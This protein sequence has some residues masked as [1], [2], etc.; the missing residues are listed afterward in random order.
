MTPRR[1]YHLTER[2]AAECRLTPDDVTVLLSAHR[3][4]VRVTPTTSRGTY[5]VVPA[6]HVGVIVGPSCRLVIQPKVPL[7]NLFHLL[8]PTGPLPVI[9]DQVTPESG[10]EALDFLAARLARLLGERAAAGLHRAYAERRQAGPYLQGRLDMA[11]QVRTPAVRK[12]RVHS[13]YDEF[14]ADVPCNQVPRATAE[15]VLASPLLGDPARAALRTA[16]AGYADVRAIP[17]DPAAFAAAAPDRRTEAYRPLLDLCRLLAQELTPGPDAGPAP[18]PAFLLDL[19]RVFEQYVT[20]G[21]VEACAGRPGYTA[22]VQP[23]FTASGP[24]AG[25]PDLQMR[26][27]VVI[28]RR[29]GARVVVDAKWKRPTGA[30][31]TSDV[32]QVLAYATALDL[33]RAM[34]VYP[35][36]R[37][38]AWTYS[39]AGGAVTVTV[40]RVRVVGDRAAC[41]RSLQC[42]GRNACR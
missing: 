4:H 37:G 5:R 22:S 27:D 30:L 38:R 7:T 23:L 24:V 40:H 3:A 35:G 2:V 25:Q 42:L 17:L 41:A 29:G 34:L 32:Y 1:T 15:L 13:C 6:G 12:D 36:R 8:D 39:L 21:L 33:R 20:R 14:T 26:P 11:A 19:D 16:L 28:E 18:C 9:A 31:L 10:A